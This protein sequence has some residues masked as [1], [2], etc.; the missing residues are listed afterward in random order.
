MGT[1]KLHSDA[2][3]VVGLGRFG[4]AAAE[5][6]DRL[7]HEVMAIERNRDLVQAWDGRL[8]HVVEADAT[9][10]AALRQ[11][12]ADHFHIAV[13][14][15][16]TSVEA[17][18]LTTLNLVDLGIEQIWAKAIS[19]A[20][21]KILGRLA[22]EGDPS[23]DFAAQLTDRFGDADRTREQRRRERLEARGM[24]TRR[25]GSRVNVVYP[26]AAMGARTAH[27]VTGK[28]LDYIEF[29]DGFAIAKMNPPRETHGFT[30]TESNVRQK[31]GI[32]VVGVKTPGHDFT[33]AVA[34]TKVHADDVLIVSGQVDQVEAFA[35][36]P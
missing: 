27:L 4:S 13:V 7:G 29:D 8:T 1:S 28:L 34:D 32:T 15:I 24:I 11:I 18:V 33:Y 12:G 2:V 35:S 6:L 17:S 9:N 14:G 5:A 20:H 30:L 16:G 22:T 21:G 31:Y 25:S 19:P 10:P 23:A 3:L 26:E 36:R